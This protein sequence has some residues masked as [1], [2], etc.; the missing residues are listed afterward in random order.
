[1]WLLDF[2]LYPIFEFGPLP[3]LPLFV[4][5]ALQVEWRFGQDGGNPY[6]VSLL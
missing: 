5:L 6:G 1:M 4:W 2:Y 3:S